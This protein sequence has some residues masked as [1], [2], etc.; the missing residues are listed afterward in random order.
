MTKEYIIIYQNNDVWS[1]ANFMTYQEEAFTDLSEAQ[2][3]AADTEDAIMILA[4]DKGNVSVVTSQEK[5]DKI[6]D[7]LEADRIAEAKHIQSESLTSIF[8]DMG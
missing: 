3:L 7:E 1:E 2:E 6:R 8:V 4:I 5:L